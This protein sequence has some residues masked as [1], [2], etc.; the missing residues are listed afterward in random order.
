MI[1][2]A[3]DPIAAVDLA[4]ELAEQ[5]RRTRKSRELQWL[6]RINGFPFWGN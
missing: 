4:L 3:G 5:Q 1:A 2:H 6:M